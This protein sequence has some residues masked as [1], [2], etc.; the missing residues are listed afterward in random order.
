MT[1]NLQQYLGIRFIRIMDIV[2]SRRNNFII[3]LFIAIISSEIFIVNQNIALKKR[4][5]VYN[6]NLEAL[7][8]E[9]K[10]QQSL[11]E[12][13]RK[14]EGEKFPQFL[15]QILEKN[16]Y[17]FTPTIKPPYLVMFVFSVNSCNP[18]LMDEIPI[19]NEFFYRYGQNSCQIIGITDAINSMDGNRLQRAI[20]ADFPIVKVETLEEKLS[21]YGVKST[22]AVLFG[23]TRTNKNL[24][25]FFPNPSRKSKDGFIQTIQRI[26][27]H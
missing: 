23:D 14:L 8:S 1:E 27:E 24:Y 15:K 4:I 13:E 21:E 2:T 18:C 11:N 12:L 20:K 22:P 10:Y 17:G 5:S 26:L 9:L 19:W 16:V 7:S 6:K 3:L 25:V